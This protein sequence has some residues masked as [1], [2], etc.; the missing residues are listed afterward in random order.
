MSTIDEYLKHVK[1]KQKAELERVR[2]IIKKL[3][4][5]AEETISYGIPTFKYK[6]KY[7]IYFAAYKDHMSIFGSM[8]KVEDKLTG[9]ELSHKG[10]LRFTEDNP[11]PEDIIGELVQGRMKEVSK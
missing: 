10:T 7:L 1:P 5:D 3:V 9:Y 6:G 4:P 11:V 2:K 8:E